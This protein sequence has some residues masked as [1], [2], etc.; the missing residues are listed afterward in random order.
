MVK[1]AKLTLDYQAAAPD[2]VVEVDVQE[3]QAAE[4][5]ARRPMAGIVQQREAK[6][7]W[8]IGLIAGLTLVS[9]VVFRSK[10]F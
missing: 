2:A 6:G 5:E 1:R 8:K 4:E 9:L 7:L 3:D 10:I